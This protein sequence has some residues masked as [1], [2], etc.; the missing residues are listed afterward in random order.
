[1]GFVITDLV[2]VGVLAYFNENIKVPEQIAV[3]GFVIVCVE[4]TKRVRTAKL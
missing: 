2:A 1:M 4:I 3:I